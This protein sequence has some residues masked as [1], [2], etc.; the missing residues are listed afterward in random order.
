MS[1]DLAFQNA[2]RMA[3]TTLSTPGSK[4]FVRPENITMPAMLIQELPLTVATPLLKFQFGAKTPLATDQLNNINIGENDVAIIYGIQ[5]LI[6]YGAFRNSRQYYAYGAS[7]DDD[8]VYKSRLSMKFETSTLI[9][10]METNIFRAE[11]GTKSEQYDGAALINPLRTYSGRNGLVEVTLDMGNI[12]A[13][14]FTPD[15]FVSMRLLTGKG[16][17]S[18]IS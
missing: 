15:A 6:G 11:N 2:Q 1:K 10:D 7:V 14:N 13:L 5:L 3:F 8:V 18:A 9:S 17:A 12:A 4:F 16:A